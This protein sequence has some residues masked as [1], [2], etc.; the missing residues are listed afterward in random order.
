MRKVRIGLVGTGKMARAHSQTYLTAARFFE[1][2]ARPVLAVVCG[3]ARARA[4]A[5]AS[6]IAVANREG[7]WM[8][9]IVQ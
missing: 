1:L 2:P 4:E 7:R 3:R 8:G 5:L 9:I 6:A